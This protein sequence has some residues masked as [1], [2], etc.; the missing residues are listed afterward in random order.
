MD[1]SLLV[2]IHDPSAPPGPEPE[3]EEE[4]DPVEDLSGDDFDTPHTPSSPGN[5]KQVHVWLLV[6]LTPRQTVLRMSDCNTPYI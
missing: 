1:Y 4:T 5:F 2:G 6:V 3:E